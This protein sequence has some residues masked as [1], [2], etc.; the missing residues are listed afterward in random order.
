M[1]TSICVRINTVAVMKAAI[2]ICS[3][4]DSTTLAA[5]HEQYWKTYQVVVATWV[6]LSIY[7]NEFLFMR[8]NSLTTQ[9]LSS[10]QFDNEN[11]LKD[12]AFLW[13]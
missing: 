13:D 9:A 2:P 12:R 5:D 4:G 1:S 11:L 6:I 3:R 7:T 8:S 10:S